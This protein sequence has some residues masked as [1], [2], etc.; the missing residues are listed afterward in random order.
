MVYGFDRFGNVFISWSRVLF[1]QTIFEL[2]LISRHFGAS[3]SLAH[4]GASKI[5]VR[6]ARQKYWRVKN[7][8]ASKILARQKYWRVKNIGASKI[9][10]CQKYWRVKNIGA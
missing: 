4:F 5:L 2:N 3:K 1:N 10:A 8:G 9:L 7:I 6:K